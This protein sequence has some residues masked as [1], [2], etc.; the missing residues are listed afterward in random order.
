MSHRII[1][2]EFGIHRAT[3][4]RYLDS[5]GPLTGRTK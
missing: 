3:I 5:E 4:K 1:E 2:R